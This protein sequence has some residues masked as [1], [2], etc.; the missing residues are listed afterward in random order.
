MPDLGLLGVVI[1]VL[2]EI[3]RRLIRRLEG[4]RHLA[5]AAGKLFPRRTSGTAD[6]FSEALRFTGRE[7]QPLVQLVLDLA[8]LCV[9]SDDPTAL[10]LEEIVKDI[11]RALAGDVREH[12]LCSILQAT[13]APDDRHVA[14]GC[15]ERQRCREVPNLGDWG[16]HGLAVL[17]DTLGL[18]ERADG[19]VGD[20]STEAVFRK[21]LICQVFVDRRRDEVA[22]EAAPT[23]A[24]DKLLDVIRHLADRADHAAHAVLAAKLDVAA[25]LER[26]CLLR[27]QPIAVDEELA[28]AGVLVGELGNHAEVVVNRVELGEIGDGPEIRFPRIIDLPEQLAQRTRDPLPGDEQPGLEAVPCNASP[29]KLLPVLDAVATKERLTRPASSFVGDLGTHLDPHVCAGPDARQAVAKQEVVGDRLPER[30]VAG[31]VGQLALGRFAVALEEG[32][33]QLDGLVR[34]S[35]LRIFK[36]AIP[37]AQV[38]VDVLLDHVLEVATVLGHK[39]VLFQEVTIKHIL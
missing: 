16:Q 30:V 29:R 39:L 7:P 13:A 27:G 23:R 38:A 5:D 26:R 28:D 34:R 2:P 1:E 32:V 33:T 35:V 6:R 8:Q 14:V 12:R 37:T 3:V 15:R 22:I 19:G 17:R 4:L 11:V 20:G 36:D 25:L 10:G 9:G 21:Y 31:E 24:P 18:E